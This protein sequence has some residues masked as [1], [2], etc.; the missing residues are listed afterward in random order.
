MA[1]RPMLKQVQDLSADTT[2]T[3]SIPAIVTSASPSEAEYFAQLE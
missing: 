2:V 3:N 1:T